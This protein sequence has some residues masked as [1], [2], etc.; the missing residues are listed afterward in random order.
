MC[1]TKNE[2]I[3]VEKEERC[4]RGVVSPGTESRHS[5]PLCSSRGRTMSCRTSKDA[6]KGDSLGRRA[7]VS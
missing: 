4:I 1:A 3:S 5:G 2:T 6:L 7:C